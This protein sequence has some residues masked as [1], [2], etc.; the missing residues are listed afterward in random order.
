MIEPVELAS[1][2]IRDQPDMA[3]VLFDLIVFARNAQGDPAME[4]DMDAAEEM[5]YAKTE[6]CAKHREARKRS[7]LLQAVPVTSVGS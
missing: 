5:L 7:F 6:D 3:E 4:A 2:L 1:R